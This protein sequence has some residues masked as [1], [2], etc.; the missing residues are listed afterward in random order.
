MHHTNV[1]QN[2]KLDFI[3]GKWL[4][5]VSETRALSLLRMGE[6]MII[7]GKKV[8]E[9]EAAL[10]LSEVFFHDGLFATARGSAKTAA[11]AFRTSLEYNPGNQN[12]IDALAK[13]ANA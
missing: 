7:N 8:T 12:S 5:P 3:M 9:E 10:F 6:S 2:G 13:L 4:N 1:P 11:A